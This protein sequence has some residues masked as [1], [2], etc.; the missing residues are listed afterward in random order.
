MNELRILGPLEV[1]GV[2]GGE[3]STLPGAPKRL[4]LLAYLV[5]AAPHGFSRRDTLLALFWPDLPPR[6]ARG[7]LRSMLHALRQDLGGDAIR[8]HGNEEVGVDPK[9]LWCDAL[10]FEGHLE[11]GRLAEALAL[12]RG[13]LLPGFFLPN[14]SPAFDHWLEGVRA[15]IQRRAGEAART[16]AA[17]A[18]EGGE[19]AAAA[20]WARKGAT[21]A[22]YNEEALRGWL[23]LLVRRGNPARALVAYEAFARRLAEELETEPADETRALVAKIRR[24]SEGDVA[25]DTGL[26]GAPAERA[27]T[28]EGTVPEGAPKEAVG[29]GPGPFET[30]KTPPSVRPGAV[31]GPGPELPS[32]GPD[33]PRP[34]SLHRFGAVGGLLL[35]AGIVLWLG[36]E[37]RGAGTAPDPVSAGGSSAALE[38]SGAPDPPTGGG[39]APP[40]AD[41]L[42]RARA[43]FERGAAE[44]AEALFREVLSGDPRSLEG[45]WGLG[46]VLFHQAPHRGE[47]LGNARVAFEHVLAF[48]PEHAGARWH[49]ARIAASE[50]DAATTTT[51]AQ[52]LLAAPGEDTPV[53]EV[54]ALA[55]FVTGDEGAQRDVLD[56]LARAPS[57]HLLA[58]ARTVAVHAGHWEGA[59][60][61]LAR[62]TDPGR[63][64]EMQAMG[65]VLRAHLA[66]ASGRLV[67]SRAYL[68]AAE[69]RVPGW[70]L[71]YLALFETAPLTPGKEAAL[72]ALHA[73]LHAWEVD[74]AAPLGQGE[75]FHPGDHREASRR[76]LGGAIEL[77]LD[78]RVQAGPSGGRLRPPG[79]ASARDPLPPSLGGTPG[80]GR[81]APGGAPSGDPRALLAR[82]LEVRALQR[83]GAHGEALGLLAGAGASAAP[84]PFNLGAWNRYLKAELLVATGDPEAALPWLRS[85][86]GGRL[87]DLVLLAPSHLR[88][89][90]LHDE[91]GDVARAARHYARFAQL[92][93]EADPELQ[94]LVDRA[95][96][97]AE[98]LVRA[99]PLA[100]GGTTDE[101]ADGPGG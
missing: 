49:L 73:R 55:A 78:A 2:D 93:R 69:A 51:L 10:S 50:G 35:A 6:R 64:T 76:Y 83:E 87:R 3:I 88:R 97:R 5:L 95:V 79:I 13:P 81:G 20:R 34:A 75:P 59:D 66:L 37:L 44:E 18:E 65:F 99:A 7:S 86:E 94:P 70:G 11:A 89:A 23:R 58:A 12:H 68:E 16:L 77:A 71:P 101:A 96:R 54:E 43:A 85:F 52:A 36:W 40:D 29:S 26:A 53:F 1:R 28:V 56:R 24:G 21:L 74:A 47:P 15:R 80:E 92:W 30:P 17:E 32:A 84:T 48:E 91:A 60:A 9:L 67:A 19:L 14:A 98:E 39:T 82:S 8:A 45:W 42:L 62:V 25:P 63:P 31:E 33:A 90:E 72:R 57:A 27:P 100:T 46:E 61:I 38:G 4:G 41:P 22:P